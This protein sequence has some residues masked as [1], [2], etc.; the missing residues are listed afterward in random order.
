[1]TLRESMN[2]TLSGYGPCSTHTL[3]EW[4]MAR[5]MYRKNQVAAEKQINLKPY[6]PAETTS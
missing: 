3:A 6:N 2:I 4:L 1:M 5:D